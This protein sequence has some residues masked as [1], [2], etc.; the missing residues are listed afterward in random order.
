M[1]QGRASVQRALIKSYQASTA[2]RSASRGA[3]QHGIGKDFCAGWMEECKAERSREALL[4]CREQQPNGDLL[5]LYRGAGQG[6][7]IRSAQGSDCCPN[8]LCLGAAASASIRH[9]PDG[10][11]GTVPFAPCFFLAAPC[12]P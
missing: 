6:A 1:K 12:H 7:A 10:S 3:K 8:S 2:S 4:C 5:S 11:A 9:L